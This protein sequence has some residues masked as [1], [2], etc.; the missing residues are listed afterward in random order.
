[1]AERGQPK[2]MVAT[3]HSAQLLP[4]VVA[5]QELGINKLQA[6]QAEVVVVAQTRQSTVVDYECSA[7]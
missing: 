1:M 2:Q 6:I 7:V 3:A 5:M 4:M